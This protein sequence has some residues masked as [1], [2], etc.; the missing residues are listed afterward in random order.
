[1]VASQQH[2]VLH[3]RIGIVQPRLG[4]PHLQVLVTGLAG[5]VAGKHRPRLDALLFQMNLEIPPLERRAGADLNRV[6]QPRRAGAF[7]LFRGDEILFMLL[8][9][10]RLRG[11]IALARLDVLLQILSCTSPKEAPISDPSR[12]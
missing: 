7:G 8:E 11:V 10:R 5:N 3:H 2:A 6:S 1:M 12:L 9:E 4:N